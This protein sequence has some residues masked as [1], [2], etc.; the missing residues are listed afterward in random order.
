[1][2]SDEND[3]QEQFRFKLAWQEEEGKPWCTARGNSFR[4]DTA[5]C[6]LIFD[7]SHGEIILPTRTMKFVIK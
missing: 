2:G 3:K 4:Y 5:T 1:M 7:G 6:V